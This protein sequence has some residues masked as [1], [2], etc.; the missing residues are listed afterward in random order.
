MFPCQQPVPHDY[1]VC[2]VSLLVSASLSLVELFCNAV[3]LALDCTLTLLIVST[4]QNATR[5]VHTVLQRAWQEHQSCGAFERPTAVRQLADQALGR[6]F[7]RADRCCGGWVRQWLGLPQSRETCHLIAGRALL[8]ASPAAFTAVRSG[9][10]HAVASHRLPLSVIT[11]T[12]LCRCISCAVR[13]PLHVQSCTV[14][15]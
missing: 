15:A 13:T 4:L 11:T 2:S 8:L 14:L 7:G 6:A 1:A 3:G 10:H 5:F 12:E 9:L